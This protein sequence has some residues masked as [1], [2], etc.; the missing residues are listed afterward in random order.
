[1]KRLLAV[2][3]MATLAYSGWWFYA[4]QDLRSSVTDWFDTQ[5]NAGLE[6]KYADLTVRGFPNRTDLTITQPMI[7]ARDGTLDWRAPFLQILALSYKRGHVIVAW[8]DTQTLTTREGDI[9][10][11]SDGLRASVIH[12]DGTLIRSNLE[13]T[14]LNMT[15]PNQTLAMA[16]VNAAL[17]KIDAAPAAYRVAVSVGSLAATPPQATPNIGPDSLG[18]LRAEL[19]LSFDQP[20]TTEVL[21]GL[22]PNVTEMALT[23]SEIRYG[24]V[25]FRVSGNATFDTDGRAT[26]EVTLTA[27]NWRDAIADARESGDLPTALGDGLVEL[28]SMLSTFGGA[29]DALDVTLGLDRGTVLIGPIPVGKLP[30]LNWR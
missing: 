7:A 29:R 14:V 5:R 16:D 26:G 24:A 21:S 15:G 10:V 25:T 18:S 3:I 11:V 6:A 30:P 8:P 12:D 17:E 27:E 19:E 1:V 13:S 4:A 22:P 2:I 23:R 9:A 20:L 28:L